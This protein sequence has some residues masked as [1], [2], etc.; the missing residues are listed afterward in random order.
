MAHYQFIGSTDGNFN[1][2]ANWSPPVVPLTG[3]SWVINKNALRSIDDAAGMNQSGKTFVRVSVVNTPFGLGLSGN[4]LLCNITDFQYESTAARSF[5]NGT[6]TRCTVR[7]GTTRED[8]L[9]IL[10]GTLNKLVV[11]LGQVRLN[12]VTAASGSFFVLAGDPDVLD[13]TKQLQID[14]NCDLT[15]NSGT[16]GQTSGRLD[17]ATNCSIIDLA[18]GQFTLTGTSTVAALTQTAGKFNWDSSGTITLADI[19]DGTFDG[20]DDFVKE[21]TALNMYNDAIVDFSRNPNL[22]IGA[23]GVRRFGNNAP[24]FAD[25]FE[26][27]D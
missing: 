22:V 15:S 11:N 5:V 13:F 17:C 10:G 6:I 27:N 18:G 8:A 12:N 21:I 19:L 7:A 16:L 23:G 24:K 26:Y 2:A 3:D 4:P 14:S 9:A 20:G 1:I 25:G